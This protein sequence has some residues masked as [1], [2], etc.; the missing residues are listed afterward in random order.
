MIRSVDHAAMP[1]VLGVLTSITQLF[2]GFSAGQ[3]VFAFSVL[4]VLA[5]TLIGVLLALPTSR[6]LVISYVVVP[7]LLVF[8]VCHVLKPVWLTRS[9]LF[10]VPVVGVAIGRSLG[11]WWASLQ[12]SSMRAPARWIVATASGVAVCLQVASGYHEGLTPKQPD[13]SVLAAEIRKQASPGDCVAVFD[14]PHYFWGLARYLIGPEWGD[15]LDVQPPPDR[16]W[17]TIVRS[18]PSTASFLG[19]IPRSD[20]IDYNGIHILAGFPSDAPRAC[21]KIFAAG[22]QF[23]GAPE[24]ILNGQIL[25]GSAYVTIRGPYPAGHFDTARN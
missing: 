18:L 23:E 9:F 16:R 17:A 15:A 8:L 13:Y 12:Y 21:K 4:A 3:D 22:Y 24:E 14:H 11:H 7:V 19:L 25:V 6:L 1:D 2:F 5:L 20:R 10:A